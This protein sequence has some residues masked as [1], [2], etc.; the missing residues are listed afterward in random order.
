MPFLSLSDLRDASRALRRSPTVTISAVT[1][2]A[3]GLAVT[4]DVS[5][6][7]DRALLRALPFR[8]PEALVTV[9]RTTPHF[10]DGPFSVATFEDLA[11]HTK[12]LDPLVATAPAGSVVVTIGTEAQRLTAQN[13][14][15]KLFSTL[16]VAALRGRLLTPTD[17]DPA[18]GAVAVLG[19]EVWRA[20]FGADPGIVGRTVTIDGEGRTIVGILASGFSLPVGTRVARADVWLPFR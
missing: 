4:T 5:S 6:A 18:Q 8:A 1:C 14:T 2:L 11:R 15:G 16:G 3:L 10:K 12:S 19:E 17:E 13:V 20:R 9:Y 7:I